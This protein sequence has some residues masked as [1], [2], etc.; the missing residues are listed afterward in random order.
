MHLNGN[1]DGRR[2]IEK[3]IINLASQLGMEEPENKKTGC[4]TY[5][6]LEK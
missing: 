2:D 1:E 4:T 5:N 6:L 3:D